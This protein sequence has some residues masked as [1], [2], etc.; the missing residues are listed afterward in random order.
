MCRRTAALE[1]CWVRSAAACSVLLRV[2]CCCCVFGAAAGGFGSG[3]RGVHFVAEGCRMQAC[4]GQTDA[5]G[6]PFLE[7]SHMGSGSSAG[8]CSG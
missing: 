5:A 2:R 1:T 4:G 7:G 3:R 8:S 6:S